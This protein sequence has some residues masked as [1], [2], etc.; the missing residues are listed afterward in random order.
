VCSLSVT[1]T[2]AVLSSTSLGQ[3]AILVHRVVASANVFYSLIFRL[4]LY[5]R[6]RNSSCKKFNF[7]SIFNYNILVCD[8]LCIVTSVWHPIMILVMTNHPCLR[9]G[10]SQM[11]SKHY[12]Y[13]TS[14][15]TIFL[16]TYDEDTRRCPYTDYSSLNRWQAN[17]VLLSA[18]TLCNLLFCN[19]APT[20]R[21]EGKFPPTECC[22]SWT[23]SLKMRLAWGQFLS[24]GRDC[25]SVMSCKHLL[26]DVN[27]FS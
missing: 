19:D 9:A 2:W 8:I 14:H 4:K 11:V 20:K 22:E 16:K 12:G 18:S 21:S 3:G 24:C 26:Q 27:T 7:Q 15:T 23:R 5:N 1:P 13:N 6:I 25:M 17:W 10:T